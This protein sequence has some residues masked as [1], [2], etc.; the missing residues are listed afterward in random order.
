MLQEIKTIKDVQAFATHLIQEE[1]LSFHPDDDFTD[2]IN[3]ETKQPLYNSEEAA[4]RNKLMA[5]C[6]DVCN[7]NKKEV[8][9]VMLPI[10]LKDLKSRGLN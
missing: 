2:Y 10:L 6:F 8:Y 9:A 1:M 5:E 3:L 7:K 4:F